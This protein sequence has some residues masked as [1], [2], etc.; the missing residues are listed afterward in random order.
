MRLI[1]KDMLLKAIDSYDKECE[2]ILIE[3]SAY[4]IYS[5]IK[6]CPTIDPWHYPSKGE[7]PKEGEKVL[8]LYENNGVLDTCLGDYS[9]CEPAEDESF[10][11][12]FYWNKENLDPLDDRQVECWQYIIPPKE[13]EHV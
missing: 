7:Y 9:Y 13:E 5:I 11:A 12:D 2:D 8:I 1:D 4:S 10:K 3:P 6:D